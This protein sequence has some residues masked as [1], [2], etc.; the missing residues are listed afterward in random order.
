MKNTIIPLMII[1]ASLMIFSCSEETDPN[2]KT[3]IQ[4]E[5]P[6]TTAIIYNLA[7]DPA[8]SYTST[9]TPL[10]TTGKFRFFSFSNGQ[11][12]SNSDSL[13]NKWDIGFRGTTIIINGGSGRIGIGG[14]K[15]VSGVFDD[16]KEAP[17]EGYATDGDGSFAIPTGSGNGWYTYNAQAG[18]IIPTAGKVLMIKTGEGKFAKMEILSY[19]KDAPANPTQQSPGR[20]Y[21]FR[22]SF[23]PDGSRFF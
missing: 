6:A 12:V 4:N 1:S 13:T 23:Q 2:P 3:E 19:Y 16:L 17:A 22:F 21:T 14:A 8:T 11:A 15:I 18:T 9:G 20:Y 10:G 7:A 5:T